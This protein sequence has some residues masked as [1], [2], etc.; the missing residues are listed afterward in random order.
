MTTPKTD[1]R[2]AEFA[3]ELLQALASSEGR[4]RKRKRNTTPDSIGLEIKRDILEAMEEADPEP[5]RIEEWLLQYCLSV[6][7]GNGGVRAM[8]LSVLDEWQLAQYS[9]GFQEWLSEGAPS[10]DTAP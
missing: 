9:P 10:E 6:G 2:P 7:R 1:L 4:R 3:R 5:A 8:A